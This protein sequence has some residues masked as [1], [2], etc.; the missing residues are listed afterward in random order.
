MQQCT[1]CSHYQILIEQKLWDL[2]FQLSMP[3]PPAPVYATSGM[4]RIKQWIK[5]S[6]AIVYCRIV[7]VH[8]RICKLLCFIPFQAISVE[9]N[10]PQ[11]PSR[12]RP[13]ATSCG[14]TGCPPWRGRQGAN[15]A[16][17]TLCQL[18]QPR[19]I[20]TYPPWESCFFIFL[21]HG[22]LRADPQC[23]PLPEKRGLIKKLLD[24]I[25]IIVP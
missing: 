25:T 24:Y 17:A 18:R 7:D 6:I 13:R 21:I 9:S 23:Q 20:E 19:D 5:S 10:R 1:T 22:N 4:T 2:H 15:F 14:I 12:P 11:P 3:M 8:R 16:H